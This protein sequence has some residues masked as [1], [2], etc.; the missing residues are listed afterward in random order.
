MSVGLSRRK[1]LVAGACLIAAPAIVRYS[2]L[3]PVKLFYNQKIKTFLCKVLDPDEDEWLVSVAEY[4]LELAPMQVY[5][6]LPQTSKELNYIEQ[7]IRILERDIYAPTLVDIRKWQ[8]KNK[9]LS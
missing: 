9:L 7:A 8:Q 4:T 5:G 2:S 6:Q 1:L 3:M